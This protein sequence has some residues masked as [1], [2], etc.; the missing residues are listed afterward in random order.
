[1]FNTLQNFWAKVDKR[2]PIQDHMDSR[3]WVWTGCLDKGGYGKFTTGGRTY[4]AHRFS[5]LLATGDEPEV[6]A[7]KCNN[8]CCVRPSHLEA[9]DSLTNMLDFV[10]RKY[11]DR[12]A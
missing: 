3:C 11:L 9:G 5:F 4:R 8:P 6:V 10:K 2:G 12:A 1:M 7:H